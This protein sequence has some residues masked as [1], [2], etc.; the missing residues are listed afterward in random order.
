MFCPNCGAENPQAAKFCVRCGHVLTPS[1]PGARAKRPR[2]GLRMGHGMIRT[3]SI[4]G[5]ALALVL[6]VLLLA[7]RPDQHVLLGAVDRQGD[8]TLHLVKLG[9]TL[10][11]GVELA[12]DV[13]QVSEATFQYYDKRAA[14]TGVG[15]PYGR[16]VPDTNRLVYWYMDDRDV[17]VQ[18]IKVNEKAPVELFR[19]DSLP[20]AGMLWSD[21]DRAFFVETRGNQARCYAARGMQQAE[22]VA[23]GDRC[24]ATANGAFV[25]YTDFRLDQ[26]TFTSETTLSAVGVNGKDER[27]LFE[28]IANVASV[29]TSDDGSHAA[30]V[31]ATR[32][33]QELH[34][35]SS[36][37]DEPVPV[38]EAQFAIADYRFVPDLDVLVYVAE[39]DDGQLQL[40]ISDSSLPI[41]EGLSISAVPSADGRY[42]AYAIGDQDGELSVYVRPLREEES[43]FVLS[44]DDLRFTLLP[45]SG[46]MLVLEQD[47]GDTVL[48]SADLRHGQTLELFREEDISISSLRYAPESAI[49]HVLYREDSGLHGL[50]VTPVDRAE[51]FHLLDGWAQVSVLNQSHSGKRIVF[52]G[53]EDPGDPIALYAGDLEGSGTIIELDDDHNAYSNAVFVPGDKTVVYTGVSFSGGTDID[54]LRVPV[55][56]SESPT[57][58]YRDA[59]LVDV[60]WSDLA[61][62]RPVSW[63][64]VKRSTSFCPGADVLT[65]DD[66]LSGRLRSGE[67]ACY[68]IR[69]DRGDLLTFDLE[70]PQ[71]RGV[72]WTLSL[73]DRKGQTLSQASQGAY[74]DNPRLT[75]QIETSGVYHVMVTGR[76]QADRAEYAL[77]AWY[78]PG[79]RGFLD[80][81]PLH[82]ST[83][84]RGAITSGSRRELD[85]YGRQVYGDVYYFDGDRG[86]QVTIEVFAG[87]I[88]SQLDPVA[89]VFGPQLA[90]VA[91]VDRGGSG[92]DARSTFVLRETGRHY[93]LIMDTDQDYGGTDTHFY[94]VLLTTE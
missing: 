85:M 50:Y 78:G 6:L 79:D 25:F 59:F 93:V 20:L 23:K 16:F 55:D 43:L 28:N 52:S 68:R 33:G 24:W 36:R 19:S 76:G 35:L 32:D 89:S 15:A 90:W 62:F 54:V 14:L 7:G 67:Q 60:G 29:V 56:R 41:A 70:S 17:A 88:D 69:A 58:L 84:T 91:S 34:I 86:E 44:G 72:N 2:V 83:R 65:A 38:S 82:P 5:A 37:G 66:S 64:S 42:L 22:R 61:P 87:Q 45:S 3:L 21:S 57:V 10:E 74:V 30:F 27:V 49:L 73:H 11:E 8:T 80:A 13:V 31:Q 47:R 94:E 71:S 92:A 39:N 18:A 4:A 77:S 40:Y 1:V 48:Y 51:G 53:G 63:E 46:R 9:N 12:R 75:A 26:A 81:K